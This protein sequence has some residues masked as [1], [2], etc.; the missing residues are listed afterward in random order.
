MLGTL[1]KYDF[2]ALNKMM[3]PLQ[4][5][6]L[7]AGII[8]VVCF[9]IFL[10]GALN[11]PSYSSKDSTQVLLESIGEGSALLVAIVLFSVVFVSGIITLVLLARNI[12]KNFYSNE[13][14]LTFTLPV[15]VNQQLL[16]KTISGFVWLLVNG[17]IVTLIV[18][19]LVVFG[20]ATE[21]FIGTQA[22]QILE[23]LFSNY[24]PA[25][26]ILFVIELVIT[27]LL[28]FIMSITQIIFSISLGGAIA[29]THKVLAGIGIYVA[30]G[31][32]ISTVASV[33][34]VLVQIGISMFDSNHY[35]YYSNPGF[36]DAQPTI[37]ISIVCTIIFSL[38]FFLVSKNS[39]KKNLNLD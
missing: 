2:K 26:L 5:G 18:V 8:G 23:N 27:S 28:S 14:Y 24:A 3:V 12:Y 15:T 32:I 4:L 33:L 17:C 6:V 35:S 39:L 13:G 38:V 1:L 22:L 31:A 20:T 25:L 29:R 11:S 34:L 19:L 9:N 21:G 10:R 7:V 36:A 30:G 37:I 16:S